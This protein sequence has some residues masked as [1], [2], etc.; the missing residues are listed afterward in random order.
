MPL[1]YF[2]HVDKRHTRSQRMTE[3]NDRMYKVSFRS[4]FFLFWVLK[5]TIITTQIRIESEEFDIR[6]EFCGFQVKISFHQQR[7]ITFLFP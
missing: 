2:H 5:T 3:V 7:S 1:I 4:L 6:R